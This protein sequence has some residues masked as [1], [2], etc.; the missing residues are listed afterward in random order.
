[1]YPGMR[2]K[3]L[4]LLIDGTVE[5]SGMDGRFTTL[6]HG[7]HEESVTESGSPCLVL[8]F[9]CEG[10][11]IR[12]TEHHL[13]EVYPNLWRSLTNYEAWLDY[14]QH[15]VSAN[16]ET[17][18]TLMCKAGLTGEELQ[19]ALLTI[20]ADLGVKA[21]HVM[22][23][24]R[25]GFPPQYLFLLADTQVLWTDGNRRG[26]PN[27]FYDYSPANDS[28]GMDRWYVHFHDLGEEKQA[29]STYLERLAVNFP[30][31]RAPGN[32]STMPNA[33]LSYNHQLVQACDIIMA[34]I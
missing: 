23:W 24:L 34:K 25:P 9:D 12:L 28:D 14:S 7:S 31:W 29:Q 21:N 11:R 1:M 15:E 20:W 26:V 10:D 22:L 5:I 18:C 6:S 13:H 4:H 33:F 30:V 3:L 8:T 17:P 16:G 2:S 27:G 19:L 32:Y